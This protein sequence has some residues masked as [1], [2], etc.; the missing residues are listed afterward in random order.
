MK[1]QSSKNKAVALRYKEEQ[2]GAPKVVGKGQGSLADR[3]LTLAREHGIPLHEDKDLLTMLEVLDVG[4]EI[5]PRLYRALAE[6]LAH[7]Y[8]LDKQQSP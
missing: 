7:V 2:D 3:M 1:A 5:P 8:R 6:V 4:V